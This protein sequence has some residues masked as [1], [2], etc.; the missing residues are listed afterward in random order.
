MEADPPLVRLY[1]LN[2]I[3]AKIGSRRLLRPTERVMCDI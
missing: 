3:R 1:P 2:Q